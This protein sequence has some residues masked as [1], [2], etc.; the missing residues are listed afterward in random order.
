MT[1]TQRYS[2]TAIQPSLLSLHNKRCNQIKAEQIL[3]AVDAFEKSIDKEAVCVVA[4]S[5]H[6]GNVYKIFGEKSGSFNLCYFIEFDAPNQ[7]EDPNSS[8]E[9][10]DRWVVR[11]P[12]VPRLGC[13][14]EK[15]RSEIATIK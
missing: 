10:R 7:V 8:S 15:H 13:L 3:A 4:S 2:N 11:M 5:F 12:K 1:P 9:K 14:D 6:G